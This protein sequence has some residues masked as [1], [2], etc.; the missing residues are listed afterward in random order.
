MSRNLI[1]VTSAIKQGGEVDALDQEGRTPLFYAA[2][3]GDNA[4][5]V[6]LIEH[7]A[8][9]NAQDKNLETPLHFAARAYQFELAELL[10]KKGA[11]VDTTDDQGNTPLSR[12]VYDSKGRDQV[13]KLLLSFGANK[14]LSNK[15]GVS[16]ET[17]AQT[18]GNYDISPFL[19]GN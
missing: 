4:I 2:Q 18:I 12:A 13:I 5:A 8:N 15:H 11:H 10:L 1:E 9:L 3:N 14:A 16:P 17:L 7:G 19:K 6:E